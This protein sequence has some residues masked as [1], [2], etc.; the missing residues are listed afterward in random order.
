MLKPSI[1]KCLVLITIILML[2]FLSS[3]AKQQPPLNAINRVKLDALMQETMNEF[4]APGMIL[5][6]YAPEHEIYLKALGLANIKTK[7]EL[8]T[9]DL[10]RIGS[11]TKTFTATV[12]LQLVDEKKISLKDTLDDYFPKLPNAGKI[13]MKMLLNHT[14]GIYNYSDDEDFTKVLFADYRHKFT[15]EK[16]IEFAAKH[17]PYFPPGKD[18]HYSNTNTVLLG[19]IVE[20]LTGNTLEKEIEERII[21][22]L[23]LKN[24]FFVPRSD[25][26][27]GLC[28]G[29]MLEKGKYVDWTNLD[30]SWGWAA[31]EIIS[32]VPDLHK[33]VVALT[34]GT[35]LSPRLQ[36]ERMGT[37]VK[38]GAEK[39]FPSARYGYN[40]F[41][42]GGF[43]GHNGGLP[44]YISYMVR[45]PK[46]NT[47]TIMMLNIQPEDSAA[48]LE[49]LKKVIKILYPKVKV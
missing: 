33:Y 30:M 11:N 32:N 25:M 3:C 4:K 2:V 19:L 29:Y 6:V 26:I 36:K 37:W 7:R 27:K 49:I 8:S 43:I 48:S 45:D 18:F 5:A 12:F 24:T 41:L 31:G 16:L 13:T 15:P 23:D 17:E 38:L 21:K 35:F 47:T 14:S 10:F 34:D 42:F 9:N 1:K 46:K 28:H 20:E 39:M 22:K 44:G 40:V